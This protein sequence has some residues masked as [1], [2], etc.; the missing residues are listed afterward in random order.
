MADCA[1]S[2]LGHLRS[3]LRIGFLLI[4]QHFRLALTELFLSRLRHFLS[5]LRHFLS[6]LRHFLSRLRHFLSRLRHFLSRLRHFLSRLRH[7]LSI[8]MVYFFFF[9]DPDFF[10]ALPAIWCPTQCALCAFAELRH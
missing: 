7:F 5:R 2:V 10:G 8:N 4:R 3:D 6:R 1:F 9:Y